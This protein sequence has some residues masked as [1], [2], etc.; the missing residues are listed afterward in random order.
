MMNNQ[1]RQGDNTRQA[2]LYVRTAS[3]DPHNQQVAI[4][5]QRALCTRMAEQ[6]G[7]VIT[8]E[9]CDIGGSG[10]YKNRGRLRHLLVAALATASRCPAR[11]R[12]R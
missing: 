12:R 11:R 5:E 1:Q 6:L 8:K 4:R 10:N 7:V 3:A 9:F 2:V